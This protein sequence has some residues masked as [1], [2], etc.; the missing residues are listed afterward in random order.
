MVKHTR[1]R[2]LL[3][4]A[5]YLSLS[6]IAVAYDSHHPSQS[7]TCP[8]CFVRSALSS[9]VAQT[10]FIPHIDASPLWC[11]LIG[12]AEDVRNAGYAARV[13]SRGPP[14]ALLPG[15]AVVS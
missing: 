14:V 6:M 15:T 2:Y 1:K 8:I 12:R 13:L 10:G 11:S 5:A 3:F 4:L 7:K 9:A